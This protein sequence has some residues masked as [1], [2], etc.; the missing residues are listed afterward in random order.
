MGLR[1]VFFISVLLAG[2]VRAGDLGDNLADIERTDTC[3]YTDWKVRC[4]DQCIRESAD[5]Q[6]GNETFRPWDTDQYCC[7]PPGGSCT[8]DWR[9][10]TCNEGR[11]LSMSS[12]CENTNRY[13]TCH[14]TYQDSQ[15]LGHQSHFRCPHTCVSLDEMCRGLDWCPEEVEVCGDPELRCPAA[16]SISDT[17]KRNIPTSAG[18][19]HY[20]CS[21]AKHINNGQYDSIDRSDEKQLETEGSALDIDISSFKPCN[22]S[23]NNNPGVMCATSWT[24]CLESGWWCNEA[25][26]GQ[27]NTRSGQ[28][29]TSDSRLCSNPEVWRN[30]SCNT[31]FSDGRVEY[32]GS[33]CTSNMACV[34]PWYTNYNGDVT[35]YFPKCSD[36]SDEIFEEGLTC[37]QH[38][39]KQIEF[40]QENF[41][42][43][44]YPEVKNRQICINKTQWLLENPS[45]SDPHNCQSSCANSSIGLDCVACS[46]SSYFSCFKSGHCIHPELVCD[47]HP[48]CPNGED[49][50]LDLDNCHKKYIENNIVDPYASFRCNSTFYGGMEIYATPCNN[51]TECA[52]GSGKSL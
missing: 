33:R 38:L 16:Y 21:I 30:V 27:C 43:D 34:Y 28:I 18:S 40:H 29:S 37:R 41:C 23:Y 17:T 10:A 12:R 44:N 45:K 52:D 5:C 36:R 49:E 47:G 42:N 24:D 7:L 39:K 3:R 50:N 48:Q 6:C 22:V 2:A 20:Y 11:T 35:Y 8:S 9:N 31:Y 51:K 14:N 26:P 19:A 15:V 13:L 25:S 46:N 4:G 32:Y 1:A